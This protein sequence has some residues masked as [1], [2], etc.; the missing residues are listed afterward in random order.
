MV[1]KAGDIL[2][3]DADFT[4]LDFKFGELGAAGGG[5]ARN[6]DHVYGGPGAVAITTGASMNNI[7]TMVR[8]IPYVFDGDIVAFECKFI[9][10]DTFSNNQFEMG[11][12]LF[13]PSIGIIEGHVVYDETTKTIMYQDGDNSFIP[14]VPVLNF[15]KPS[16]SASGGPGDEYGWLR[17]VIDIEKL[18]FISIEVSGRR[19][20]VKRDMIGLPMI[21]V[22]STSLNKFVVRN[23][24]QTKGASAITSYTTDWA[25]ATL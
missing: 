19:K 15:P 20:R 16:A 5:L 1:E 24:T 17:L 7:K 4:N 12:R 25:V 14:F 8:N 9:P 3:T 6:T 2:F 23:V 21:N 13:I 11:F 22:S 18:E 10:D